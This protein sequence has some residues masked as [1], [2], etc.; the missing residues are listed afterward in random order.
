MALFIITAKAA[1]LLKEYMCM[2]K[3]MINIWMNLPGK[4][5][6]GKLDRQP[7]MEFTLVLLQEKISLLFWKT[8]LPMRCR[9]ALIL[10]QAENEFQEK[11]ISLNQ[12]FSQT[13]TMICL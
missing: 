3:F 1:A 6:H 7:K 4:F 9:K 8:R 11:V 10:L 5:N 2:K 13:S 12:P